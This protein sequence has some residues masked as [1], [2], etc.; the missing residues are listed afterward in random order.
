[1]QEFTYYVEAQR[2]LNTLR[3]VEVGGTDSEGM[4]LDFVRIWGR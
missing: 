1:M 3:F 2:G 4:S